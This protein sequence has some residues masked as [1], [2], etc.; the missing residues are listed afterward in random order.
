[1]TVSPSAVTSHCLVH[2]PLPSWL[3]CLPCT[4]CSL[5][6]SGTCYCLVLI[7]SA[8]LPNLLGYL[9]SFPKSQTPIQHF[10]AH[11][12]IFIFLT[13]KTS[14]DFSSVI[15]PQSLSTVNSFPCKWRLPICI[16]YVPHLSKNNLLVGCPFRMFHFPWDFLVRARQYFFLQ[17]IN[18]FQ[19][20]KN[21]FEL[22][23]VNCISAGKKA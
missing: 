7:N 11:C 2:F 18:L 3:H 9:H 12:H 4:S 22:N 17:D 8:P 14:F 6:T 23:L 13:S 15:W 16:L 21:G 1:M 10:L 19:K 5:H 20:S